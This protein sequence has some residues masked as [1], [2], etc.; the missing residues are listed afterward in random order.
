MTAPDL[1]S[2]RARFPALAR[3]QDGQPVVFTDA[4]GGSQV[5]DTVIDAVSAYYRSGI[6]NS[7]GAFATSREA[8]A[9]VAAAREAGADLVG[10]D[11]DQIVFGPNSTSLLLQ[12]SRAFA[13]TLAPGDEVVVTRLDHDANIRPWVLAA[14][15]AGATVRWVDLRTDDV[16][17]DAG[18]FEAALSDRTRL[19]AFTLASNAV[20]IDHAG[21][22]VSWRA[23][24]RSAPWW[25]STACTWRSI[26]RSTSTRWA[27]T[28][29]PSRPTR[30]SD[31]T[32]AC[33]RCGASCWTP[34]TRTGCGRRTDTTRRCAGRRARPTTKA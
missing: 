25:P 19:V 30:C 3:T 20:G 13:R 34:W 4:P 7:A 28:S 11:P 5:P 2:L 26:A 22:R 16:T 10:A 17:L 14:R 12:L 31:P 8:D 32:W 18:S 24:R 29:W 23:R 9:T 33:W 15:D 27:P 1:S 21:G 6:S